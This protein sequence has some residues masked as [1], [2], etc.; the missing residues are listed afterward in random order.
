[1]GEIESVKAVSDIYS[2][3]DGEVIAVIRHWRG[4][5]ESMGDDPYGMSWIVKLKVKSDLGLDK[6]MDYA[7]YEQQC[8]SDG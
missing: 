8:A 6:L 4:N 5:L 1:M 2:P 7:A 3:V